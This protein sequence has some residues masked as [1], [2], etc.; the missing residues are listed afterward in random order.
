[1]LGM[2][3]S[4]LHAN[5]VVVATLILAMKA[6]LISPITSRVINQEYITI[7]GIMTKLLGN[8]LRLGKDNT[9]LVLGLYGTREFLGKILIQVKKY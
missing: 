3:A 5:A 4:D 1:M 8:L 2:V 7:G 9:P 6:A